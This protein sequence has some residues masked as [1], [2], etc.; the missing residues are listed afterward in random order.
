[1]FSSPSRSSTDHDA[2]VL[3]YMVSPRSGERVLP[4]THNKAA[5]VAY[6]RTVLKNAGSSLSAAHRQ[7]LAEAAS[8]HNT[9]KKLPTPRAAAGFPSARAAAKGDDDHEEEAHEHEEEGNGVAITSPAPN[10]R[11]SLDASEAPTSPI[12]TGTLPPSSPAISAEHLALIVAEQVQAE[13]ARLAL[14][15]P[16]GGDARYSF[17]HSACD[18][19]TQRLIFLFISTGNF[20][21]SF[22]QTWTSAVVTLFLTPSYSFLFTYFCPVRGR[23]R[24]RELE[25]E[26]IKLELEQQKESTEAERL[27]RE[28][29]QAKEE[30]EAVHADAEKQTDRLGKK[31][32]A[33]EERALKALQDAKAL[34]LQ[35]NK[36]QE[37]RMC[38][39]TMGE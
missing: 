9:R 6:A 30:A 29:Q 36:F 27:R 21:S 34:E 2:E 5:K 3:E 39:S 28:A 22:L 16:D 14:R 8:P 19:N 1:M 18:C 25:I 12:A 13:L 33:A 17:P 37:V 35:A 38:F 31:L 15:S 32:Q 20:P 23:L 7:E 10:G 11:A 24:E 4:G 26:R